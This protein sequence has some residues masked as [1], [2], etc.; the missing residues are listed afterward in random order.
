ML[1][2]FW[3]ALVVAT[4]SPG[5]VCPADAHLAVADAHCSERHAL[6]NVDDLV[7]Y[8]VFLE[9]GRRTL[10]VC[11]HFLTFHSS[12]ILT[13]NTRSSPGLR[14]NMPPLEDRPVA[15]AAARR[16]VI[17]STVTLLARFRG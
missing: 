1:E 2:H 12:A 13:V 7:L 8:A 15:R 17:Y 11:V 5:A 9:E 16:P 14:R 4:F 3:Q 10:F 6:P